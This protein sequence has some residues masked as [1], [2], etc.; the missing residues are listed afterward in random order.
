M[1]RR[2][3]RQLLLALFFNESLELLRQL[4]DLKPKNHRI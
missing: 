1:T 2:L 3:A 4:G